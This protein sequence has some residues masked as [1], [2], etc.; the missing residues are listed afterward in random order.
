MEFGNINKYKKI[1]KNILKKHLKK[2]SG[3][4]YFANSQFTNYDLP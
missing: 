2:N 4:S 1:I 3:L